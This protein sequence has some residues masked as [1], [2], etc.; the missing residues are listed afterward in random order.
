[1]VHFIL[2]SLTLL[3]SHS[4]HFRK[5]PMLRCSKCCSSHS[6]HSISTK[7]YSQCGDTGD[8]V[9]FFLL[10]G[11]MPNLKTNKQKCG[12]LNFLLTQDHMRLEISKR[13]SCDSF[14]QIPAKPNGDIAYHGGKQIA[15]LGNWPNLT[16]FVLYEIFGYD[17]ISIKI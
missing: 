5:F 2:D 4:V 7:L 10:L 6:F 17:I 13:Y 12:A 3:W 15:F 16:N 9:L 8:T 11:D 1:M 14:Y